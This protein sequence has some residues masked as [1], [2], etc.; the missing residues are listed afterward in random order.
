[1]PQELAGPFKAQ[2]A[3]TGKEAVMGAITSTLL[4]RSYFKFC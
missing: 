2:L 4:I 3:K 1:M